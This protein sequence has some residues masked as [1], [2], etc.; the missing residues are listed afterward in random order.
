MRF[1]MNQPDCLSSF[2]SFGPAGRAPEPKPGH[3]CP[4]TLSSKG[5]LSAYSVGRCMITFRRGDIVMRAMFDEF[6]LLLLHTKTFSTTVRQSFIYC[7]ERLASWRTL[8]AHPDQE[9]I[10]LPLMRI[11]GGAV[12]LIIVIGR[13]D[14]LIAK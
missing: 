11:E 10:T 6:M 4:A 12:S 5:K 9:H 1:K 13:Q 14:D 2:T 3:G 8:N 7:V